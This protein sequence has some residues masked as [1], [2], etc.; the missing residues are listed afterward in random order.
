MTT[1]LLQLL[2]QLKQQAHPDLLTQ[3]QQSAFQQLTYAWRFPERLNLYGVSGS[4]KTFLGW[5]IARHSQAQFYPSPRRFLEQPSSSEKV[6]I[7][8]APSDE[9]QLRQLLAT[10]QS[11]QIKHSLVIT[12]EKNRTNWPAIQLPSPT[13]TD[14]QKIYDTCRQW[15]FFIAE[16]RD[17]HDCRDLWQTIRA[18]C[19]IDPV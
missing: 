18:I 4:G 8:N 19:D 16:K 2:N 15:Q 5:V 10:L 14:I 12:A 6:I 17:C 9:R 11:R 7:D 13:S 1:I 3:T